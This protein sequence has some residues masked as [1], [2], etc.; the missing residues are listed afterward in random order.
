MTKTIWKIFV[1]LALV[2]VLLLIGA[3]F[4]LRWMISD[5]MKKDFAAQGGTAAAEPSI[6]FGP[7]PIL[8]SQLTKQ[9][10][11]VDIS[12]P[13]TLQ[14]SDGTDGVPR[15]DGAPATQVSIKDLNIQDSAHPVAG[16]MKV[17]TELTE[18]F[19]LAQAQASMA[20]QTKKQQGG[21]IAAQLLAG[22]IKVTKVDALAAE[23][24]VRVEFTDG[25]AT[26]TLHPSVE[27]GQLK[28]KADKASVL[29][30]NL[31]SQVT[32]TLTKGMEKQATEVSSL[33]KVEEI[34][35]EDTKVDVRLEGD[36]VPLQDLQNATQK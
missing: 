11:A 4:G 9:I 20:E 29:G 26:L 21:G 19:L 34:K 25:A 14:I 22:L 31:P 10:P 27:N 23:Q 18:D 33:L 30:M 13:S 24:A 35:V 16:H 7:T 6:S 3:E 1:S 5:Q 8:L 32:D 2:F 17:S 15:V 36:N 12:T 28:F